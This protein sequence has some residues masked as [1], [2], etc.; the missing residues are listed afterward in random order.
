MLISLSKQVVKEINISAEKMKVEEKYSNQ[1]KS[2]SMPEI[3]DVMNLP[4]L[5]LD[6][7]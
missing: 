1:L 2:I 5:K 4:N 3:E 7:I 6:K